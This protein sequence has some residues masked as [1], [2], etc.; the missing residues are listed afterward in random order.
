MTDEVE[1]EIEDA[2]DAVV[3]RVVDDCDVT[4]VA[5]RADMVVERWGQKKPQFTNGLESDVLSSR[6]EDAVA[7]RVLTVGRPK[8]GIVVEIRRTSRVVVGK[9]SAAAGPPKAFMAADRLR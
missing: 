1:R 6:C 9:R 5:V 7:V 2:D 3:A 8:L 4:I